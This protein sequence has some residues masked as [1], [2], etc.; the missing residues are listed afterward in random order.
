MTHLLE[1]AYFSDDVAAMADFYKQLLGAEPVAASED[2]AI[3]MSGNTKIFIHKTYEAGEGEMP[4]ENHFAYPVEDVD[5][6]CAALEA[7]GLRVEVAPKDYYWGR[8]AYL[9]DPDGHLIELN[10]PEA[11]K[12]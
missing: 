5:G 1:V 10:K 9:R 4:P 2:M 7:A 6:A 3:F 12:G 8:S 11:Y